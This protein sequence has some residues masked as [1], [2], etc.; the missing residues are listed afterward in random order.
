MM[1]FQFGTIVTAFAATLALAMAGCGK[2]SSSGGGGSATTDGSGGGP[3]TVATANGCDPAKAVDETASSDVTIKFPLSATSFTYTPAC[4]K[5]K[6]GSKVTFAGQFAEHPLSGGTVDDASTMHKD[7]SSPI[8]ETKTGTKATF[9]F[10]DTGTFG[11]FCEFHFASGMKGAV[12][13]E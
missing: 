1:T 7:A 13:V 8:K 9:T 2:S 5:I 6:K 10:A 12:F 3:T 11:F 4:I